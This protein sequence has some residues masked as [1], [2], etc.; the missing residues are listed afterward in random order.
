MS[1]C[2]SQYLF[3]YLSQPPQCLIS[4]YS[5]SLS[6]AQD[7]DLAIMLYYGYIG[8]LKLVLLCGREVL[9][10]KFCCSLCYRA[11]TEVDYLYA[12]HPY[13]REWLYGIDHIA[14]QCQVHQEWK[15]DIGNSMDRKE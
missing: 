13:L 14:L 4:N 6:I 10:L 12:R 1:L 9:C 2:S 8:G 11:G 7:Y 3:D 5:T 15:P